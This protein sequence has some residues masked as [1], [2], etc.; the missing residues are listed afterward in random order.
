MDDIKPGAAVLLSQEKDSK[1]LALL[2][3]SSYTESKANTIQSTMPVKDAAYFEQFIG[4]HPDFPKPGITFKDMMPLLADPEAFSNLNDTLSQHIEAF[5]PDVVIGLESRGFILGTPL[6]I[7]T[8]LPFIPIR[9]KGK[10]PGELYRQEY[11]LEYG[12]DIMEIQKSNDL[13]GKKVCI[14]D[15]L[16]A[17]GGTLEA[18]CNLLEKCGVNKGDMQMLLL[19]ELDFLKGRN[20]VE[21]FGPVESVLHY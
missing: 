20:R 4:S 17:T 9:K 15:D 21:K 10:L 11:Q 1:T 13:K 18:S 14:V 16:L 19:I 7:K 6:A 8:K 12:T 3:C 2:Q 5:K